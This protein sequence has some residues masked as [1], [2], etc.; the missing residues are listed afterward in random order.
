MT[1]EQKQNKAYQQAL[2]AWFKTQE[3]NIRSCEIA[4]RQHRENIKLLKKS[5]AA[6]MNEKKFK[7]KQLNYIK[8][9]IK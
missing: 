9:F 2:K 8:K 4:I 1:E 7:I 3:L 5:I 6:E